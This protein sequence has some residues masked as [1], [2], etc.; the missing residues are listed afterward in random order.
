MK[1]S[2]LGTVVTGSLG[3]FWPFS[4]LA[5]FCLVFQISNRSLF[6]YICFF[7]FSLLGASLGQSFT[8]RLNLFVIF[9][10]VTSEDLC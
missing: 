4:L 6:V 8:F 2:F 5:R 7:A 10:T 3:L 9:P 1:I